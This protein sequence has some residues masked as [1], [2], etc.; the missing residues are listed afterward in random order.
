MMASANPVVPR[1]LWR[2]L[3]QW[4]LLALTAVWF[5]LVAV[6]FYTGYHEAAEMSD[7]QLFSTAELLLRLSDESA[8]QAIGAGL[9]A[10]SGR[11]FGG[12]SYSPELRLVMWSGDRVVLDTHGLAALLPPTLVSGGQTLDL[13]LNGQLV[14]F[15]AVR[16]DAA[17]APGSAGPARH[18]VILAELRHLKTFGRD[19]ALHIVRPALVLLPLVALMLAWAIRRGLAPVNQLSQ[20]IDALDVD[21]G[22]VLVPEQRYL[23]L[24]SAVG[25]IN[26]L[27]QRL[28]AQAQRERRF[29][30]DV[31][32]ELRTPLTALVL[33]ARVVRD[34]P[35]PEQ[36]QAAAEQVE[37]EALRS[38]R[39]LSQL[40]D[41]ARAEGQNSQALERVDLCALALQVVSE[42]AP[43]AHALGQDLALEAPLQPVWVHGHATMLEL[44]LRNLVDNAIRHT[45][46]DTQIEVRVQ[47]QAAGGAVLA[48][49]DDGARAG[50]ALPSQ[51]GL[52]IGLTLVRRIADWN[53]VALQTDAPQA[54]WTT[55][56]ALVWPDQAT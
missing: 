55:R 39:I 49:C 43:A 26:T 54:P 2:Y 36:R 47:T 5:T 11:I 21:S 20:N 30:S 15:R 41:L 9:V 35:T 31:A 24:S 8:V 18:V 4:V 28:Q 32:H 27:V 44:A 12:N 16:A 1:S 7:G 56:F 42:Q 17:V 3:W 46:P 19:V 51:P 33:Q 45:P 14:R 13:S 38:G 50:A 22:Q 6:A 10:P 52:G 40:L 53:G 29:T 23:E 37:H 48:V 34:G 25:A